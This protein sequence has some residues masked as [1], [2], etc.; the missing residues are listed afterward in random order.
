AARAASR[1]AGAGT[2][3]DSAAARTPP[4]VVASAELDP[5]FT[6]QTT[7]HRELMLGDEPGGGYPGADIRL[8]LG[9]GNFAAVSR[10]R[11]DRALRVDP[12]FA[13]KKDR[14]TAA[15]MEEAYL[16]GQWRYVT[17]VTGR[18]SRS[19][20]PAPLDG[21][22]VGSYAD[23]YDHLYFRL[24]ASGLNLTS[25]VARLDD[26]S[27]GP[28]TVAQRY[29]TA[30]RIGVRWRGLDVA[31]TEAIV[32]GGPARGFEPALA[33]PASLLNLAQYTDH[34]SLNVSYALDLAYRT[35]GRG[36]YGAQ[37]LLDDFQVDRCGTNCTEPSSIGLTVLAEAVP[38]GTMAR[39]FGSYT[40]VN[41]LTYRAPNPWERYSYLGLGLGRGQSDYDELRA[42]LELAPPLG[43]P[44]RVYAAT[45]RQ[46]EG[47][48]RLPFP[49]PV[50]YATTPAIFAGVVER[51]HRAGAQWSTSGRIALTADV[52]Y[53]WTRNADHV[54]GRARNGFVGR[55]RI[56]L[57]PALAF[58]RALGQ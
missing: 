34:Q 57:N 30:H 13:G 43:G 9:A 10:L 37:F 33:N 22:Q 40:R 11:L 44:L 39:A 14:A 31:A 12:E 7:G 54:A 29:F 53:D 47:D 56:T 36:L 45:R 27:I 50:Q 20:G 26:I 2:R 8:A 42:G 6:A 18:V 58:A 38:T 23:S 35:T 46:G 19:W 48:Y 25:I 3:G 24:G 32:Y 41:N 17:L 28:D 51:V 5:F 55:A 15:R 16:G 1:Y 4:P 52:G 21:L 49:R